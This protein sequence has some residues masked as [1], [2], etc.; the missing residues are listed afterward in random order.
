[1]EE[2]CVASE[3][4]RLRESRHDYAL[5]TRRLLRFTTSILNMGNADFRPFIAKEHWIWHACHQHYH[6]ME[7]FAHYDI[8]DAAGVRMAEGHKASFCLEDNACEGGAEAKYDCE[9][10]GDQGITPGCR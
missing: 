5:E 9:N 4:Y 3:A 10:Y 2:N 7:V 1:M 8:L 6:S